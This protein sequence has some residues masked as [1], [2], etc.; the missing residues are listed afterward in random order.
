MLDLVGFFVIL[1]VN[2]VPGT[3]NYEYYGTLICESLLTHAVFSLRVS[4]GVTDIC[5]NGSCI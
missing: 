1:L 5:D 2:P 3:T 4:K